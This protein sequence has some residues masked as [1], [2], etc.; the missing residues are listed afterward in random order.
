MEDKKMCKCTHHKI[1]PGCIALIGLV[2]L[3]G[4]MNVLTAGA[5]SLI[6]PIILIVIGVS[7]MMSCKCC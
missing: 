1:V 5:V 3:L 7:K 2:F 4:Q 6:W